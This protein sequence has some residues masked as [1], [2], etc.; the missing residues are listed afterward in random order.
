MSC[1]FKL[2]FALGFGKAEKTKVTNQLSPGAAL[3]Q[4][5]THDPPPPAPRPS[6][7]LAAEMQY[8]M[9]KR[10]PPTPTPNPP[11]L[12]LSPPAASWHLPKS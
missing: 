9:A 6:T 11:N 7:L 8:S 3:A 4:A 12:L 10:N 1:F 5:P 2:I